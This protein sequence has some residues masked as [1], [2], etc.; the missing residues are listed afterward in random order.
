MLMNENAK[1]WLNVTNE[2]DFGIATGYEPPSKC[3][4]NKILK[5]TRTHFS[6]FCACQGFLNKVK[7][8]SKIVGKC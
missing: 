8:L 1:L 5:L 7:T 2:R 6:Q 3:L 4:K